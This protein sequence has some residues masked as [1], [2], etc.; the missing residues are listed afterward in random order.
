[1]GD[2]SLWATDE[3]GIATDGTYLYRIQ[4]RD[5]TP[6]SKTWKLESGTTASVVYGGSYTQ[7]FDNMHYLAHDHVGNRYLMGHYNGAQFYVTKNADPGPG[8]G[9]P[10]TPALGSPSSTAGGCTVT[11]SNYDAA[12]TW[13]AS[14]T[15]GSASVSASGVVTVS[16]VAPGASTTVTVT[17]TRSGYPDGSAT[18]TCSAAPLDP[19]GAPTA[20]TAKQENL[21]TSFGWTAPTHTGASAIID[22]TVQVQSASGTDIVGATC[23]ATGVTYC[24][25]T[26]LANGTAYKVVVTARNGDG[27]GPRSTPVD[28]VPGTPV[29]EALPT[30][31]D[32]SDLELSDS[33]PE[34]GGTVTLE[35]IGFR[36]G[37]QVDFWIHSTPQLLGSAIANGAGVA[38]LTV[39]LPSAL[40]GA[41]TVQALGI[42]IAGVNRNLTQSLTIAARPAALATTGSD[43]AAPFTAAGALLAAGLVLAAAGAARRRRGRARP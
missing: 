34:Q 41:H 4:W 42:S 17:A 15:T 14:A 39:A 5:V 16:G 24:S 31:P 11:I 3:H 9:N 38:T 2:S 18:V 10:L 29:G 36:P 6:N 28:F 27:S 30:G 19:P 12:F 43:A 20:V 23:T 37:T 25:V 1:M 21:R 26:G 33:T 40:T 8:P 22:Y 13:G 7:P 32:S 35:A